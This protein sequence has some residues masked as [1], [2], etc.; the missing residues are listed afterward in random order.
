MSG[1]RTAAVC[2][3]VCSAAAL[4]A[5]AGA[6]TAH[7]DDT[8]SLTAQQIA[9]RSRTALLGATSLHMTSRGDL[10]G[11]GAQTSFDL[12]LD[13][14]GN[15]RGSVSLGPQEGSVQIV[16][17]GVDVWLKPDAAF[18]KNDVP[19]NGPALAKLVGDRYL[20]GTTADPVLRNSTDVCDLDTFGKS[21]TGGAQQPSTVLTKGKPAKVDGVAVIPVTGT[22]Q[23]RTLTID[24]AA[25]GTPYPVRITVAKAGAKTPE[26]TVRFDNFDK[27]VP[28]ATPSAAQ[29]VDISGLNSRAS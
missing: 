5:L 29:S 1:S 13:K 2:A 28:A 20:K 16:K 12:T 21:I 24:V 14:A 18:W 19:G 10:G 25:T 8:G 6:A 23:G 3:T 4:A 27:P 26:T 7:A 22:Q 17:R 15:C 9:Q 11:S